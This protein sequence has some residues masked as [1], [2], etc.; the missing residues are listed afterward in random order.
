MFERKYSIMNTLIETRTLTSETLSL[1]WNAVSIVTGAAFGS[2]SGIIV[3]CSCKK[4][5]DN[6][7]NYTGQANN[8]I[9]CIL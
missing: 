3:R 7:S 9:S 2:F 1:S 4:K 6:Y 8:Q 5:M